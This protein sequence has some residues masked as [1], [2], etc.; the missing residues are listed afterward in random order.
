MEAMAM[1]TEHVDAIETAIAFLGTIFEPSDW[2]EVRLLPCEHCRWFQLA[3]DGEARGTLR[4]A[5]ERNSHESE[6][7]NVYFGAHPRTGKG[8]KKDENVALFRS[9]FAD[10][11]GVPPDAAVAAWKAA[12]LPGPSIVVASGGGTHVYALLEEPLADPADYRSAIKEIARRCESD[13]SV[14][15]PERVLR[16]PG[17]RNV[18]AKYRDR[19]LCRVVEASGEKFSAAALPRLAQPVAKKRSAKKAA[20]AAGTLGHEAERFLATGQVTGERRPA[21][22]RIAC[23]MKAHGW[24]LERAT[25]EIVKRA[26]QIRPALEPEEIADLPRQIANA[27]SKER[28]PGFNLPP[29]QKRME[30]AADA[31]VAS[32]SSGESES[33][34]ADLSKPHTLTDVGNCRRLANMIRGRVAYVREREAWI[35]WDGRRWAENGKHAVELAAKKLSDYLLR[36]L[37]EKVPAEER[38]ERMR[39]VM[40]TA[41]ARRQVAAISLARS[42]PGVNVSWLDFDVRP[43]DLCVRNG[44]IDLRSGELRPHDP[45]LRITQMAEVEYVPEAR[46]ELWEQF[47]REVTSDDAELADFLQQAAGIALTGDVSDEVLICH[48]GD[49]SNGKSTF[50]EALARMLGDYAAAAPPGLFTV[51]KTTRHPAE[52][53][54]LKGAR[55]VTSAE[56]EAGEDFRASLIKQLTGGDTIRTR[57]MKENY[58]EMRPTWHIHL[59]YNQE[60]RIAGDD[61]GMA[62]RLRCVPW[63]ASFRESADLSVK[64]RLLGESERSGILAWCIEGLRK[65][66]AAGQLPRPAAVMAKTGGYVRRSDLIGEFL[67]ERTEKADGEVVALEDLARACA[68]W[69]SGNGYAGRVAEGITSR[70]IGAWLKDHRYATEKLESGPLRKKTVA[71]G[72]RLIEEHGHEISPAGGRDRA[73]V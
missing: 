24:T 53:A 1:T 42:E 20:A 19:P 31:A 60:P 48:H 23:D 57:G 8:K 45:E 18:K 3:N 43:W 5:A 27:F 25:E 26:G 66:L 72:L 49:G 30:A 52:I 32:V 38:R 10:F 11:D 29:D 17:S 14:H 7:Q 12:G 67:A 16:L 58:W 51:S 41:D 37:V 35:A 44:V 61:G 4:W 34:P 63:E 40:A 28:E 73:Y 71:V 6:P 22:F 70:R 59:A 62:R 68:A 65:R 56:Q 50:L 39:W 36:D 15:N 13:R 64:D 55:L 33:G 54:G 21:V 2:I 46:S 69:G 9:V 47:I